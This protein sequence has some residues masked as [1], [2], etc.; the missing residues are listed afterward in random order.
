MSRLRR[1]SPF[2]IL[3]CPPCETSSFGLSSLHKLW[4]G[5]RNA[6]R[7]K[8][9]ALVNFQPHERLEFGLSDQRMEHPARHVHLC[10]AA[11]KHSG[12]ADLVALHFSFTLAW[13]VTLLAV[14]PDLSSGAP[15][16]SG[17]MPLA[18]IF[19]IIARSSSWMDAWPIQDPR[20]SSIP[21]L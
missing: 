8:A 17:G 12:G 2:K 5:S 3:L 16:D 18:S 7:V 11:A 10:A 19:A 9:S 6:S 21:V 14:W 4:L 15:P 20:T 1:S 13:T